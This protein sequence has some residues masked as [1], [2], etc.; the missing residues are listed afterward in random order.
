VDGSKWQPINRSNL[1][2]PLAM[3]MSYQEQPGWSPMDVGAG[4]Q[5]L[6][7][8]VACRGVRVIAMRLEAVVEKMKRRFSS[9]T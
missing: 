1:W 9:W 6:R 3:M 8:P 5:A 2:P 4:K 7:D